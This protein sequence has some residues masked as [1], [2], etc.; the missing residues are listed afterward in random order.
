MI[1]KELYASWRP[2]TFEAQAIAARSY[3][4]HERARRR[5]D[6]RHFDVESTTKDQAYAG[7]T[8]NSRAHDAARATRGL[9]LTWAGSV[10][11]A[12]Y[13]S[14]TGGRAASARDTWP[15]SEG[16]EFNLAPPI[17]ASP[18]D[19]SDA[20]SPVFR[21]EVERSTRDVLRRFRA[22]GRA[23]GASIRNI[24]S[25]G[26]I[27]VLDRNEFGRPRTY[28]VTDESGRAWTLKAEDIR[29][30]CN[31]PGEPD[32]SIPPVTRA[33]RVLSGDF[34]AEIVRGRVVFSGRGFGH[35]VG[36]SQFGAEGMARRGEDARTILRH[37]Y[38][39]AV[40]ERA[41]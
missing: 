9:V 34:T 16:F 32:D 17:Q 31:H 40:I 30:A 22:F 24:R 12:Y 15:T 41:Y 35:G 10:L 25:L 20:F 37:Y 33:E 36:M 18:R 19:D 38:P 11:R 8:E 28:R 26:T 13:S 39:G 3:A 27:R 2:V 1:A 4:L 6:G 7:A 23:R 5:A 21:W 29:V 14:T